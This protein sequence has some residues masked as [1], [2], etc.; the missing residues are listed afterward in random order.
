[1]QLDAATATLIGITITGILALFSTIV[2][3]WFQLRQQREQW[4]REEIKAHIESEAAKA[5]QLRDDLQD[6]YANAI[7]NLSEVAHMHKQDP[8]HRDSKSYVSKVGEAQKW[9]AKVMVCYY[10]DDNDG[11]FGKFRISFNTFSAQ[12]GYGNAEHLRRCIIT[13]AENDPRLK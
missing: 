1:M 5:K 6:I 10:G 2:N 8:Q 4:Q 13:F 11:E 12:D 9:A 7:S 3:S